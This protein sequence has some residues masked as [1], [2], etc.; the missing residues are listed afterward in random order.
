[1]ASDPSDQ[2]DEMTEQGSTKGT[3]GGDHTE[4]ADAST[5][6]TGRS[7]TT[8]GW[9]FGVLLV[10]V[11]VGLGVGAHWIWGEYTARSQ[12]MA[13][14]TQ[15]LTRQLAAVE[16]H[17]SAQGE[18][19]QHDRS[20][21][22]ALQREQHALQES[23]AKVYSRARTGP[24]EWTL[25]EVE[26]LLII[27]SQRLALESD[28]KTALVALEAADARLRDLGDPDLIPIREQLVNDMNRLR[29]V[30]TVDI[31]GLA[32]YLADLQSRAAELP[33]KQTVLARD[34]EPVT[35]AS[36][37]H[38]GNWQELVDIIWK[39]IKSLVV[40]RKDA[41]DDSVFLLPDQRYFLYQNLR[42]ELES[43][44]LSVLRRDT[45]NL[46]AS[47]TAIRE[48]LV[49]YFDIKTPAVANI[50]ETLDHMERLNLA[51]SLPGVSSSLA[52]LR[53]YV[54]QKEAEIGG[55]TPNM[56]EPAS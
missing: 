11:I 44:R 26:Y 19:R 33:L 4:R 46:N 15:T 52:A 27:A 28:A 50:L 24:V 56:T 30:E 1:M 3:T 22:E 51:P 48:W 6:N 54:E 12:H 25:A 49:H 5:P 2:S 13:E 36:P 23:L 37:K 55:T 21:I 35:P 8:W 20:E 53:T 45:A 39:E 47:I 32:L 43:A 18:A 9:A 17:L 41:Q 10:L 31:A 38:A 40:V 14:R 16:M 29:A 42:L 34:P 7:P